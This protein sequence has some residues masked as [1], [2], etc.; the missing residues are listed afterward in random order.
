MPKF[1]QLSGWRWLSES[2]TDDGLFVQITVAPLIYRS[3]YD[4]LFALL[5]RPN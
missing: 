2:L 4:R 3:F 1:T 5:R